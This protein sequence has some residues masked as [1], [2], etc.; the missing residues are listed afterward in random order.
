[1]PIAGVPLGF[2]GVSWF[3]F[4]VGLA[5]WLPMFTIVLYRLIFHDPLPPAIAPMLFI[6]IAPPGAGFVAYMQLNGGTLDALA[7]VLAGAGLFIALLVLRLAGLYLRLPFTLSWWA[8]TFPSAALATTLIQYQARLG[9]PV[10]DWV[11]VGWLG[12]ATAIIAWVTLR[13]LVSA[14]SGR[15][16]ADG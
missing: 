15:L 14:A 3:F 6:L 11:S 2:P 9:G 7:H 5:F 8:F 13:T 12:L 1:V 10:M 4:A 16:F